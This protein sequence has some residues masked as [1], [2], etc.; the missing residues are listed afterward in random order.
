MRNRETVWHHGIDDARQDAKTLDRLADVVAS[1]GGGSAI[2][3]CGQ[4][5]AKVQ[6]QSQLAW[7][8]GL[9]VGKTGYNPGLSIKRGKPLVVFKAHNYGWELRPYNLAPGTA[10]S[11][12]PAAGRQR[13]GLTGSRCVRPA[14]GLVQHAP[15]HEPA[16]PYVPLHR[17]RHRL[18]LLRALLRLAI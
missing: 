10:K 12:A 13:D 11:C 14:R 7:A 17:R 15:A 2:R 6:Y 1:V 18:V 3:A 16:C 9:N 8:V 5:D 4:P